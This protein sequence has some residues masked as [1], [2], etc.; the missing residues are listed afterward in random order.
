MLTLRSRDLLESIGVVR[1]DGDLRREAAD[2]GGEGHDLDHGWL[3]I[4]DALRRD[5]DGGMAEAGLSTFGE[6]EVEVEEASV[7]GRASASGPSSDFY[8][9]CVVTP[10]N[11]SRTMRSTSSGAAV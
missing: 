3:R 7:G 9:G 1:L 11:A 10:A 4:E 8:V 2:G 5:Y 6:S